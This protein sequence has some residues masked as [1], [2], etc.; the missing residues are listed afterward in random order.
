[1]KEKTKNWWLIL[2]KG[3]VLIVLSFFVFNHPIGSLLG[4]SVFIGVALLLVGIFQIMAGFMVR[5]FDD[6]WGWQLAEGIIDVI[7]AIILLSNPAVTAVVF[8][9]V[10]GFWMIFYGVII[11]SGSFKSKKEGDGNWWMSLLGG[12]L[13]VLVGWFIMTDFFA[14]ALAITTWI[15]I[16]LLIF[17]IVNIVMSFYLKKLNAAIN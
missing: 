13:T 7:F 6:N 16:G 14:G 15:G 4:L 12:I 1:M 5:K 17:G 8:P 2:L 3:I 9:F 11:F 10:V